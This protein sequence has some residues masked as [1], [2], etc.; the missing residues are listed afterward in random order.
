[1]SYK[2][3][4]QRHVDEHVNAGIYGILLGIFE[5]I[6]N[7][8]TLLSFLPGIIVLGHMVENGFS[9]WRWWWLGI[10]IVSWFLVEILRPL[11]QTRVVLPEAK[12]LRTILRQIKRGRLAIG[13]FRSPKLGT[14]SDLLKLLT[15]RTA[16]YVTEV[17]DELGLSYAP[18]HPRVTD[19]IGD[20]NWS[21]LHNKGIDFAIRGFVTHFQEKTPD[22]DTEFI[23]CD[24]QLV[25]TSTERTIAESHIFL[26]NSPSRNS[27]TPVLQT[28][29][30]DLI[31]EIDDSPDNLLIQ[32]PA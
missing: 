20:R 4:C 16:L 28:I 15:E 2:E 17:C 19:L 3:I 23:C 27:Q 22:V 9:P 6:R 13:V 25:N 18:P 11:R 26:W 7:W 30:L 31:G 8:G 32:R 24:I 29:L 10:V 14:P 21:D 12:R 1:M 5:N